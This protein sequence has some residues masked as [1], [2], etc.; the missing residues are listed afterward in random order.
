MV[1]DLA[2]MDICSEPQT[3]SEEIFEEDKG[4]S[5]DM[6]TVNSVV[7]SGYVDITRMKWVVI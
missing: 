5:G 3:N 7:H 6:L 1:E 4:L 2:E